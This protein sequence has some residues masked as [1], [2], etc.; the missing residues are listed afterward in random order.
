MRTSSSAFSSSLALVAVAFL[1][2]TS[3][4]AISSTH[5]FS[6]LVVPI[7]SGAVL[8]GTN[9]S[10]LEV[11]DQFEVS[12]DLDNTS[13]DTFLAIFSHLKYD[14][15]VIEIANGFADLSAFPTEPGFGTGNSLVA[16][17]APAPAAGQPAGTAIGIAIGVSNPATGDGLY[18]S[19]NSGVVAIAV[20]EVVGE[21]SSTIVH[22]VAGGTDIRTGTMSVDFSGPLTITVPEPAAVA[23][24]VAALASVVAVV[25]IR[26][27]LV[28]SV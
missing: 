21:G 28:R 26:R 9:L 4:H 6:E 16:L 1:A 24:S 15:A 12:I 2:T 14:P 17:S 19:A 10:G 3:A 23:S 27:R 18:S 22:Q 7:P 11:G 25:S 13:A 20:F 8:A 5:D